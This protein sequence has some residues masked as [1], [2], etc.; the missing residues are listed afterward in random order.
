MDRCWSELSWSLLVWKRDTLFVRASRMALCTEMI[1]MT[2]LWRLFQCNRACKVY[3]SFYPV[4]SSLRC[5]HNFA[6][7]LLKW[8]MLTA[9]FSKQT[10]GFSNRA[11]TQ[12]FFFNGV[13]RIMT[14]LSERASLSLIFSW[15]MIQNNFCFFVLL[16]WTS[17]LKIK[18]TRR[19]R[20][21][22]IGLYM[23]GIALF[24]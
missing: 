12:I 13:S 8:I 11:C 5:W 7:I 6:D 1:T 16:K 4:F 10:D 15:Q 14:A 22:S 23:N 24:W 2:G 3:S 18:T 20:H 9:S 21:K 17:C 19:L